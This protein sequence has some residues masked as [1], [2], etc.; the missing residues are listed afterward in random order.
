MSNRPQHWESVSWEWN[1]DL[2]K[3][4][5]FEPVRI[6]RVK[7]FDGTRYAIRQGGACMNAQGDWEWEPIP[8]SRTDE[9][10]AEFRF[11]TWLDAANAVERHVKHPHGRFHG[12]NGGAL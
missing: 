9:W 11:T 3:E 6:D 12:Y 8:S 4:K 10:L 2:I 5:L 7:G 1:A